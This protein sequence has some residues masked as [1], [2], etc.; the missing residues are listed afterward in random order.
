MTG[1]LYTVTR[2]CLSVLPVDGSGRR[3][4]DETLADWRSERASAAGP[5]TAFAVS[6]RAI[7]AVFRSVMLISQRELS[8]RQGAAPLLRLAVWSLVCALLVVAF[9]WNRS[10]AVEGTQ[11]PIGLTAVW[12]GAASWVVAFMPLLAFMSA[13]SGR[14]SASL[15]PRLGPSVVAGVVMLAAMGWALPA[16]GQAWREIL[17]ELT[18]GQ[19]AIPPG[20]QERSMI[21]LVGLLTTRE[22]TSAASALNLRLVY[23][24]AVPLLLVLG[25]TARSLSGR[26]RVAASILPLLVFAIPFLARIDSPYGHASAWPALLAAVLITRALVRSARSEEGAAAGDTASHGVAK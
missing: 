2:W 23:I 11:V 13:A 15:P 20:I 19:G 6:L 14:R 1:P 25:L 22:F 17:F 9:N 8:S 16:A 4:F 10:I 18:G 12:L 5:W 26:R 3:V 21:E 7:A 24:V